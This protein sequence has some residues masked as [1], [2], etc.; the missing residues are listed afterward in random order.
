MLK[1]LFVVELLSLNFCLMILYT[2]YFYN[3]STVSVMNF[4]GQI[5]VL[6]ILTI[7]AL[8]ASIGLALIYMNYKQIQFT[9]IENLNRFKN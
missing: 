4:N 8:E 9:N 1:L 7:S 5:F 2:D 6:F 3:W